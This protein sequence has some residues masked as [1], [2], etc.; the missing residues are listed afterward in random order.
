M[1]VLDAAS[2]RVGRVFIV[3]TAHLI[4]AFEADADVLHRVEQ[5]HQPLYRSAEL[6]Y[7][8]LHGEHHTQSH[9]A[10]DNSACRCHRDYYVFHL[11]DENATRFLS[12][13]QT[14]NLGLN[15]EQ[16]G[17]YLFPLVE[18]AVFAVLQFY[19]L[20]GGEKFESLIAI[21]GFFVEKFVVEHLAP[22][23]EYCE[24]QRIDG[25]TG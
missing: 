8:I 19:F 10:I 17:L 18:A 25:A 1:R 20:H 16:V 5:R 2:E 11:I 13:I 12:L 14:K 6:T 4:D 3:D 9:R 22:A 15:G 7:D 23:Q 24:P 21:V